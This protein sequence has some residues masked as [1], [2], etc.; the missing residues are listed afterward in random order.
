[1]SNPA[2]SERVLARLQTLVPRA[3][4]NVADHRGEL[5]VRIE[6]RWLKRVMS[7]ISSD[8]VLGTAVLSDLAVFPRRGEEGGVEILYMLGWPEWQCRAIVRVRVPG[9]RGPVDSVTGIWPAADWLE[10]EAW[11]LHGVEFAGHPDLR[12]ILL[13]ADA[14]NHPLAE[15]ATGPGPEPSR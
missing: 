5:R 2:V 8:G 7:R 9:S 15:D 6:A 13:P 11:D 3:G 14:S 10:R 12:R 1:M 4:E